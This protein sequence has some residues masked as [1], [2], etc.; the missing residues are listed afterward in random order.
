MPA[1]RSGGGRGAG[2][3]RPLQVDQ[4]DANLS[5][6]QI[7]PD[8]RHYVEFSWRLDT[9]QLPSP[10]LIGLVGG[11]EFALGVERTIRLD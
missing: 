10:M 4:G 3:Y 8:S 5:S 9:S 11:S 6:T 1:S 7:D 2:E